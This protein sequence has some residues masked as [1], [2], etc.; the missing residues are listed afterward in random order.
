MHHAPLLPTPPG[1]SNPDLDKYIV[2][3]T[4]LEWLRN[5]VSNRLAS[6]GETWYKVRAFSAR[7]AAWVPWP[8]LARSP[9]LPPPARR[10]P[11]LDLPPV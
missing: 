3:N 8:V 11:S 5:I 1:N 4:V 10:W 6:D 9:L 2:P 7:R